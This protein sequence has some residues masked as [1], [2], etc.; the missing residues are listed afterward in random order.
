MAQTVRG[1]VQGFIILGLA[2][3]L[4]GVVIYG[5]FLLVI[6][7]ILLIVFSFVGLGILITSFT[8]NEE[9]AG[10]V[11]MTLMFPMMFMSGVFFPVNQMPGFMQTVAHALPLTY[12]SQ[13]M[14]KVMLLGAGVPAI[15][16]EVVI[17]AVFGVVMLAVAVPLFKKAMTR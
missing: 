8:E 9:T 13:A 16:T 17:L 5:S 6:L 12:A 14:R 7:L 3:G 2:M 11:M 10:M 4:F 1:M 15:T